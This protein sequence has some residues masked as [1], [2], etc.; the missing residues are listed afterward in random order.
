MTCRGVG[1]V[2]D[3]TGDG[4]SRALCSALGSFGQVAAPVC[5]EQTHN[6]IRDDVLRHRENMRMRV[7]QNFA[8]C[9][10]GAQQPLAQIAI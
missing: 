2:D 3:K 6:Y 1:G 5:R 8:V 7:A 9:K 10:E 4:P